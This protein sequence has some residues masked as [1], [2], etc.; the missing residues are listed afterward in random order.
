MF[1]VLWFLPSPLAQEDFHE[2][3]DYGLVCILYFPPRRF[4]GTACVRNSPDVPVSWSSGSSAF[5]DLGASYTK[6]NGTVFIGC[7]YAY[8]SDKGF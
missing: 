7:E 2:V 4:H 1:G 6:N 3:A 8:G 5:K